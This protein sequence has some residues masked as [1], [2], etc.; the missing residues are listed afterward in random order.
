MNAANKKHM[1]ERT[2]APRRACLKCTLV[3]IYD[4]APC[5]L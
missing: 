3:E 5:S 4:V 1:T 2:H